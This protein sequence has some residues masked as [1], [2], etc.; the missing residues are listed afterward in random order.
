ME[1][2]RYVVKAIRED[3]SVGWLVGD[4]TTSMYLRKFVSSDKIEKGNK[5]LFLY[6]SEGH[7]QRCADYFNKKYN[8]AEISVVE[9]KLTFE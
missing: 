4:P 9:V 8:N 7:A 5:R 2:K 1:G 6:S 3:G